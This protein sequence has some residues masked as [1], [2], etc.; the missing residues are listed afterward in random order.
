MTS[1]RN[2]KAAKWS[3]EN[4]LCLIEAYK[5]EP[6]LYAVNTP[7]YHNKHSRSEALKNVCTTVSRIR[8]GTTEKECSTKFY[9]LRNQ[10]NV[11]NAK[12]KSSMKSGIGTNNVSIKM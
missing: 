2:E 6:C 9:N 8:P 7:N 4:I 1:C 10:F 11:E 3:K 12:I 5:D